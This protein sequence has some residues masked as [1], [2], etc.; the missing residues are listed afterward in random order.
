MSQ[1]NYSRRHNNK[2]VRCICSISMTT[3]AKNAEGYRLHQ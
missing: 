2:V 1:H 3:R